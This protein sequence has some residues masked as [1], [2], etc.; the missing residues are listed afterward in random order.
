MKKLLILALACLVLFF[1]S[2]SKNPDEIVKLNDRISEIEQENQELQQKIEE[3]ENENKELQEKIDS[4]ENENQELK[5]AQNTPKSARFLEYEK[6]FFEEYEKR[7]SNVV[8]KNDYQSF[9]FDSEFWKPI[10]DSKDFALIEDF[11]AVYK[12]SN[13]NP[14]DPDNIYDSDIITVQNYPPLQYAAQTG[15]IELVKFMVEKKPQLVK[16]IYNEGRGGTN[17]ENALDIKNTNEMNE[18]LIKLGVPTV[19]TFF[20]DGWTKENCKKY[21]SIKDFENSN[22]ID[23]ETGTFFACKA[24][25]FVFDKNKSKYCWLYQIK[26]GYYLKGDDITFNTD[27]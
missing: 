2:C 4:L 10:L 13:D 25:V 12:V 15:N 26:D 27:L 3:L 24:K 1:V 21:A 23:I 5:N 20:R 9:Y 19:L 22:G 14:Y 11:L 17:D 6:T 8:S 7:Y 18:T 16:I